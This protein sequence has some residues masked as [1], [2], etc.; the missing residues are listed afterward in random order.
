MR[1]GENGMSELKELEKSRSSI[2]KEMGNLGEMR[3]GSLSERVRPCGKPNCHCK[4]PGNRGHG[5]TYSLTYK[6]EGKTK[7]ETIPPHRVAEVR[8]QLE[9]RQRFA[10]LSRQFLEIN[11]EICRLR[12]QE[13][14]AE[15]RSAK[16]NSARKSKR[17]S[18]KRSTES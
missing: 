18:R 1:K 11:E 12:S 9:N 17:K 16:K 5:P 14:V 15:E 2:L 10:E 3:R 13:N 4:K 6:V 7:M 8:E